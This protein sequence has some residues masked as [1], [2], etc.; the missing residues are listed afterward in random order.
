M[1][2]DPAVIDAWFDSGAMPFAQYHY[3]F[4]NEETFEQR[5]PADFICEAI[6][7]TRGW[8]Y[9]LLAESVLLF[10]QSSYEACVCL[11]LILD[12]EGQK[13]SKSRGNVVEPWDVISSHGADA[14]RWY[15][16]TAQQPWAGYRFSIETVGESVRQFL[17]P[18]WNTY[19]FWVLYAN[20]EG[21]DAG[22]AARS[23]R[24]RR[25][26]R[27]LGVVAA[28]GD[29]RRGPRGPRPL[30]LDQRGARDLGLRRRALQL[31]RAPQPPAVLGRRRRR[32]RHP[33]PLP[34]E[35]AAL[36][37]PFMPFVADEIHANLVGGESGEFGDLPDSVHLRDFPE[38]ADSLR[39]EKLEADMEAVRRTVELGRAARAQAKIKVRQPLAKAVVVASDEEREAIERHAEMVAGELNVKEVEFV[40]EQGE[41]V[42]Y[43]VKPNFRSLGPRFGKDMPR[44]ADAIESL[45]AQHVSKALE[46]GAEI[47]I[48]IEGHD[49]TLQADDVNLVMEPLEGYEVEAE[50]GHAVALAARARRRAPPRGP[51]PRDRPRRPE[52]AQGGRARGHRTGFRSRSTATPSCS[53]PPGPTSPTS[54]GETLAT[55][56]S[57]GE[58]GQ[59]AA[60]QIEGRELKIGVEKA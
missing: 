50:A 15:Y 19:S 38:A 17:L 28:P 39:D 16:L 10:D 53:T 1:R 44:V 60:A 4:E 59:A 29:R 40:A 23:A 9:T 48:S 3:P 2:R 8:F 26:A 54:A 24:R 42:S 34:V 47:G 51:R 13:M 7:Q 35:I 22:V 57:Y 20:T 6:D 43:M 36:V 58:D 52:R 37:A 49:H 25:R 55:S 12:P 41:L 45:D 14:F 11:G 32:L 30:R 5:F 21:I 56:V 18:L 27:P 46:T 31:V 33:A